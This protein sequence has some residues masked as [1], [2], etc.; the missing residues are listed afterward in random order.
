MRGS[1]TIRE[2]EL[3]MRPD[4]ETMENCHNPHPTWETHENQALEVDR[5]PPAIIAGD[6][7]A[8]SAVGGRRGCHHDGSWNTKLA[9]KE[10]YKLEIR[11]KSKLKESVLLYV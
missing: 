8:R 2:R 1:K 6:L 5:A 11:M 4:E 10:H 9:D 7:F 3:R